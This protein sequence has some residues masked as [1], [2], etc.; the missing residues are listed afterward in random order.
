MDPKIR[1]KHTE[2]LDHERNDKGRD[3]N[4]GEDESGKV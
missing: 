4:E 3:S 1:E 2:L